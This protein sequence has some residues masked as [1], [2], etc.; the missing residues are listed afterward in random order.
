MKEYYLLGHEGKVPFQLPEEWRVLKN[1]VLKSVPA[2]KGV[3]ELTKEA[4]DNPVGTPRIEEMIGPGDKVAIILDDATRPTPRREMLECLLERLEGCGVG[5]DRID[6]VF[7]LGTHRPL[8]EREVEGLLGTELKR[9]LRYHQHDC[10][11]QELVSIGTLR[12][13]GEVKIHPVVAG[14]DFRIALG[15]ILPHPMNGFGGGAKIILPGVANEKAIQDHHTALLV[16]K[17]LA[18][19][20][21]EGNPFR[22]EINEAGRLSRLDFILNA[23]YNASEQVKGIVAG[24]LDKAHAHGAEWTLKE[25]SATFDEPADVSIVSAFPHLEGPQVTKPLGPATM[26]T[27]EGG[28]VILYSSAIHGGGFPE[29]LL[30]AFDTAFGLCKNGDTKGLILDFLKRRELIVPSA[31]MDFN[32][33]LDLTLLYLSRIKVVMVCRDVNQEQAERLGFSYAPSLE[34]AIAFVSREK[35]VATVNI[36]PSGGLAIPIVKEPVIFH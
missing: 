21:L 20:R 34:E 13:A 15:S 35:P 4:L 22:D 17:G 25:C 27:R 32:C 26:I 14:A 19:G 2:E 5:P 29:P 18:F 1:A 24:D 3:Y 11:S 36:L 7:A 33:A 23:V 10:K 31:P 12:A 8:T 9:K 6:L 30:Q 28:T 16:S